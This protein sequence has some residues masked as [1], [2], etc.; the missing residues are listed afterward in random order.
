LINKITAAIDIGSYN[1]RMIIV[2][3]AAKIKVLKTI[4]VATNLIKNLSYSNEFTHENIRKTLKCLTMFSKKMLEYNVTNYRCV[5]T[6]AC[7][8]VINSD[9]FTEEVKNKT[10]LSVEIISVNEEARLCFQSC[11]K[12]FQKINN[13]GILFDIGGGSTEISFFNVT[14]EKFETSSIPLG[15]IN[16]SEKINIHGKSKI[17]SQ[18]NRYFKSLNSDLSNEIDPSFSLGSCSTMSTLSAIYQNLTF[19]DKK[20]IEGSLLDVCEIMKIINNLKNLKISEMLEHP[21]IRKRYPLLLNGIDILE[22]ILEN[23][24][25]KQILVSQSGLTGGMIENLN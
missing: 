19:F 4:S 9:F 5:A 1:C 7:R 23:F 22:K 17:I 2:N 3:N 12:Y 11:K 25:I 16:L 15:V 24:P 8:Q 13:E 14:S 20:K 18:M 10:G 6:E 21:C